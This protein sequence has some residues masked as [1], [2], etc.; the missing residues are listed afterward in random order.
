M[1]GKGH[2]FKIQSLSGAELENLMFGS[3]GA[4]LISV[5]GRGQILK[6]YAW[7]GQILKIHIALGKLESK[8]E[9]FEQ[10]HSK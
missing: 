4:F 8:V 10:F 5:F 3:A 9:L 6:F 2:F 1:F 7:Q